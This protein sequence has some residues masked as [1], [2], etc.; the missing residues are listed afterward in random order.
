M[1][2]R[3]QTLF[4]R[5][6][7]FSIDG[8]NVKLRFA[9]RIARENGWSVAFSQ[10]VIGEYK[11]F[12]FLAIEAGHPVTPSEH[13]DQVWHL[14]LVYTRSYWEDFCSNALGKPLH[15]GPTKGG[16]TEND[17]YSD[18][19][20]KTLASYER[21][22]GHAPPP[23]IWPAPEDRFHR[24]L[25]WRRVNWRDNWVV[26]KQPIKSFAKYGVA[27]TVVIGLVGCVPGGP[28]PLDLNGSDFL[29]LYA[30][31]GFVFLVWNFAIRASM[32]TPEDPSSE[33]ANLGDYE[34]AYL[35]AKKARV[36]VTASASLVQRG[37]LGLGEV[38]IDPNGGFAKRIAA[39]FGV[40]MKKLIALK[41][42]PSDADQI[43][44]DVCESHKN[45]S[46]PQEAEAK[47]KLDLTEM[48]GRLVEKGFVVTASRAS[49]IQWLTVLPFLGLLALGIAKIFVGVERDKPV[50]FLIFFSVI[51]FITMLIVLACRP[52][53]TRQA[54]AFLKEKQKENATL[55]TSK[56]ELTSNNSHIGLAVAL[57]GTGILVGSPL[58]EL[59]LLMR[60]IRG[61]SND[62]T[63][64]SLLQERDKVLK[65]IKN[66][67][68]K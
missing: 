64:N 39:K 63:N 31:L 50:G 53:L 27:A 15:H 43:E 46:T 54:K 4:Q 34:L 66:E 7:D 2:A 32:K 41:P 37:Y 22:F 47:C 13:V 36:F 26:P 8:A 60:P 12:C 61:S 29:Q 25:A 16:Q 45:T 49:M 6:D 1:N 19:Y 68:N 58:D 11:R 18:W 52:R 14:H 56:G 5:I 42:L 21:L 62:S 59:G 28:N 67:I 17:K 48:H 20:S 51:C 38:P 24:D 57:F 33:K 23:D 9:D 55:R 65:G 3:Q 40:K 44:R 10:R 30:L 35:Q